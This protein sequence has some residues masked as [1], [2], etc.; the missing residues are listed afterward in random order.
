MKFG[1][2]ILM[3][4][5]GGLL[6]VTIREAV[7]EELAKAPEWMISEKLQ[8]FTEAMVAVQELNALY[9][10]DAPQ[11][12]PA[13][14]EQL[15]DRTRD[16]MTDAIERAGLEVMEYD[17]IARQLQQNPSLFMTLDALLVD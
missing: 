5:A 13:A 9:Q 7:S 6:M 3:G 14:A 8:Q 4:L 10:L 1:K 17:F 2:W 15:R 11:L 16:A 12:E